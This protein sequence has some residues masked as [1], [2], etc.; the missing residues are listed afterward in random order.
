MKRNIKS[1]FKFLLLSGVTVIFTVVLFRL[2]KA[3][4]LVGHAKLYQES[5]GP[6]P[7]LPDEVSQKCKL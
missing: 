6:L 7:F 3:Q 2:L 1:V 4:D 5:K